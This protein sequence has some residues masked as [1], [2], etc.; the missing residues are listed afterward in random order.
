MRHDGPK[1]LA[2]AQAVADRR[3]Q[4]Y[5]LHVAPLANFVAKLRKA[6]PAD[7][8]VPDFDPWDGGTRARCLF[9]FEAPG[10]RAVGSGFISRDN[11]DP[12]AKNFWFLN[13]E[14]GLPRELTVTWNVVPWY[15]GAEG[16]IRAA[17]SE[18]VLQAR[19]YLEELLLQLPQLQAIVLLGRAAQTTA[20]DLAALRP[21]SR[22]FCCPHPSARSLNARPHLRQEILDCLL[23]ARHHLQLTTLKKKKP[24]G[25]GFSTLTR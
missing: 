3:A 16:R 23:A 24:P 9:L 14:A 6:C 25:G 4:L 17:R 2:D 12:T 7:A 18:D 11:P 21:S 20:P 5:E 19:P 15:L 22:V 1:L 13:R 8:G 10:A